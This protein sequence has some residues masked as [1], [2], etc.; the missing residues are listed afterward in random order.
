MLWTARASR[1]AAKWHEKLGPSFSYT[2]AVLLKR[3][4][5][6]ET[7]PTPTTS[8]T[9][10]IVIMSNISSSGL[11][12]KCVCFLFVWLYIRAMD[13]NPTNAHS[14]HSSS[15]ILPASK[16]W[17]ERRS[18]RCCVQRRYFRVFG[19]RLQQQPQPRLLASRKLLLAPFIRETEWDNASRNA[20]GAYEHVTSHLSPNLRLAVVMGI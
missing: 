2:H 20:G 5:L 11:S 17:G 7:T 6:P 3:C 9:M 15:P 13:L 18:W 19:G 14:A 16:Q 8:D 10:S 1:L 12:K 4:R